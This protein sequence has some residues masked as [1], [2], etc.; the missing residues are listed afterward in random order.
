M[1]LTF[2][3]SGAPCNITVDET[4]LSLQIALIC[5]AGSVLMGAASLMEGAQAE[6]DQ[7]ARY[8]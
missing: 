7:R 5:N 6:I 8:T 4:I 1:G 3:I 2:T